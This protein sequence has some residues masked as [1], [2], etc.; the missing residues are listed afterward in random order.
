MHGWIEV[1]GDSEVA[2][3]APS[4]LSTVVAVGLTAVLAR[5]LFSPR[6]G[7]I[8]GL[9][10]AIL[11]GITRYGQ[12]VRPYG[13]A[14]MFGTLATLLL[15]RALDRSSG[16]RWAGYSLT[17][18]LLGLFQLMGLLLLL[19]H[20]AVV[21]E[22]VWRERGWKQSVSLRSPA[23]RWLIAAV[24]SVLPCLP[25]AYIALGQ[26]S[27]LFWLPPMKWDSF[28]N[29]PNDLFW[30]PLIGWFI[31]GVALFAGALNRSA[32]RHLALIAVLPAVGLYVAA[33]FTPLWVPRYVFYTLPI[34]CL[35][36]AIAVSARWWRV[37]VVF[38]LVVAIGLPAHEYLRR[39]T[40]HD[41]ADFRVAMQVIDGNYRPGDGMVYA[42]TSAWSIRSAVRY[43][44]PENRPRD[45]LAVRSSLETN[46]LETEECSN[47]RPCLDG[48]PRIWVFRPA[49]L[50]SPLDR[51][52]TRVASAIEDQYEVDQVW[53][54][55]NATVGLYVRESSV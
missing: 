7:L 46:T 35:L 25:L 32:V 11:P 55:G 50:D 38:A 37:A 2:L 10:L 36:A 44:L 45:V 31:L 19:G 51:F 9:L 53:R 23:L 15:F 48:V 21:T 14:L 3:R 33:F 49:N 41:Q 6:I 40:G 5:R 52:P 20:A 47:P 8:A 54:L 34:W 39:T 4:I 27:Q 30:S 42:P 16:W 43:Y 1:F 18:A 24:V 17:V 22:R 13:F 12:E 28:Q 26:R 29:L